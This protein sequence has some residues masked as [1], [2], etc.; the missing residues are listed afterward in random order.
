MKFRWT[1]PALAL[2]AAA[3]WTLPAPANAA[4]VAPMSAAGIAAGVA[5]NGSTVE[6]VQ[7]RRHRHYRSHNHWRGNNW[8]RHRHCWT[9]RHRVRTAYGRVIVRT[10]RR[11]R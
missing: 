2:A 9:E 6:H 8:R 7:Y 11:C 5:Q 1:L 10:V 4:P 3:A